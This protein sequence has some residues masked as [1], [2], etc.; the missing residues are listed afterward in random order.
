M[1]LTIPALNQLRCFEAAARHESF[2]AAADELCL[3][4][5]AVSHQIRTLEAALNVDLFVRLG[6]KMYLSEGGGASW[7]TSS[8]PSP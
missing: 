7:P 5:S 6:R 2:T 1:A 3:T 8:R 4:P